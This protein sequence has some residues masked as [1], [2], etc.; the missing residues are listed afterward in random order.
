M[1]LDY[2]LM[3]TRYLQFTHSSISAGKIVN[4]VVENASN[5]FCLDYFRH[6]VISC[7]I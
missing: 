3:Q 5:K 6:I 7:L 2:E 4:L 1:L